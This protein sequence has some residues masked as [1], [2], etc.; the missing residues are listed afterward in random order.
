NGVNTAEDDIPDIENLS[1]INRAKSNT[2][3]MVNRKLLVNSIAVIYS[4]LAQINNKKLSKNV[5]DYLSI[6]QYNMF[7]KIYSLKE[8]NPSDIFQLRDVSV[9]EYINASLALNN[10]KI[11]DIKDNKSIGG[12]ELS[13]DKL[14]EEFSESYSSLNQMIK[15]AEKFLSQNFKI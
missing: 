10:A 15:N 4:L 7:R 2:Y 5:S 12:L 13:A 9:D 1:D 11:N 3:C 6:S 14:S 8:N